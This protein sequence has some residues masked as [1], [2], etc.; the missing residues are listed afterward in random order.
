MSR[1]LVSIRRI[2]EIL[3]I[4]GADF[5]ATAI[6]DG[7]QVIVKKTE[8]NINDCC[9]FF[10]IDSLLPI[11]TRYKFL[12]KTTKNGYNTGYRLRTMKLRGVLSQGLALPLRM[13]PEIEHPKFGQE[14]T[15]LL[16]VVKY[17][18][19]FITTNPSAGGLK[20]GDSQG[21][22]PSFIPKTDQERI[23]NLLTYFSIHAN[24]EFEETLKLD[25]S[26]CTM[27]CIETS[28]TIWQ[29]IKL[30]FGVSYNNKKFGVCSRNLEIKPTDN[31]TK[32]F[33]NNGK[34]STYSQSDFWY[35]AQKY[36]VAQNLPVGFAIQGEL[37]GPKIQSNH[38]K[39]TDLEY[40]VFDI[41]DIVEQRYLTPA[42][43]H[44]M[45]TETLQQVPHVPVISTTTKILSTRSLQSLL[46]HVEGES[47][48]PD[49]VSEGRVYKSTDGQIT[50]KV[51]SNEY[52]LR[53][54]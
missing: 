9:V 19:D 15:E 44:H 32:T 37:I 3:P 7:W 33:D 25:G 8:F 50:F 41:Y 23:Q 49:T 51:I 36:N 47:M 35:V 54:K 11:E 31:F 34:P 39:V 14:V 16:K 1:K 24:T 4:E 18:E 38:E 52:L 45:M 28:P 5:I 29:R 20:V 10:E 42:E 46:A 6:V 22:F 30:I 48:H 53:K 2:S 40:Y 27:Y 21:K 12:G 43:R 26:S 17:E 13:F